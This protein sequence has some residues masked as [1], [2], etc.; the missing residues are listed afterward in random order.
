[1]RGVPSL[2]CRGPDVRNL[3]GSIG[4]FPGCPDPDLVSGDGGGAGRH[5]KAP[6][7]TACP[8]E[9]STRSA[10]RLREISAPLRALLATHEIRFPSEFRFYLVFGFGVAG[11]FFVSLDSFASTNS[12]GLVD[13]V[14]LNVSF[15]SSAATLA[16]SPDLMLPRKISS[17]IGSSR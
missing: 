4:R 15:P 6:V 17:A 7:E 10:R 5:L 1:M 9:Q 2:S 8:C 12:G 11:S 16:M 14:T 13:P 3:S